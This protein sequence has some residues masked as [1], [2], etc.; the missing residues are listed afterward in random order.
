M[1]Y[2]RRSLVVAAAVCMAAAGFVVAS[3]AQGPTTEPN[4]TEEEKKEFLLHAK[5]VNSKQIGKGVTNPW[6]LTLSDGS[7]THDAAFQAVDQRQDL[8]Q[9]RGGPTEIGFR[10]SYHYNIAAYELAKLLGLSDMVPVT[11]ERKWQGRG[12]ALSWWI[13]WKWDEGMR[14]KQNLQPP[15]VVAWNNQIDKVRVF[16][17]LIYD[18]DRN[19]GNLLITEDWKL[20]IIDFTRAFRHQKN[21]QNPEQLQRCDRQLLEKLRQLNMKEVLARTDPHLSEGEVKALM[22]R[23]D[24]MVDYFMK[25]TAQK[26]ENAVLY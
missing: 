19:A 24:K 13:S 5:I 14:A 12:G 20:W 18:T 3:K 1:V 22:A 2:S 10:D 9:F 7:L 25:L 21:L 23:R 11:V 4:L 26:G 17:K 15:D 6:R 8:V 16:I